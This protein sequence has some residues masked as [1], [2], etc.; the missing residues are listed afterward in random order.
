[1]A[2]KKSA[3]KKSATKRAGSK[4]IPSS[5]PKSPAF[6]LY[7]RPIIDAVN[8]GNIAEM[9]QIKAVATKQVAEIQAA[10]TKLDAR[11]RRG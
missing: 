11:L 10:L 5:N 7:G 4:L 3:T 9:K 8:R 6:P 2:T 1:M